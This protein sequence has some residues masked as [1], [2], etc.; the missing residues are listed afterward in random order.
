MNIPSNLNDF[1]K[2]NKAVLKSEVSLGE[3]LVQRPPLQLPSCS[4]FPPLFNSLSHAFNAQNILHWI[5]V[6]LQRVGL[7]EG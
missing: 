4:D 5:H 3:Y 6:T 7:G 2:F 1:N